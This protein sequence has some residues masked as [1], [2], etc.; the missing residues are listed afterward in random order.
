MNVPRFR[1]CVSLLGGLLPACLSLALIDGAS[2]AE[3]QVFADFEGPTYGAWKATGDAFGAGPATGAL[4]GQMPLSGFIG[5]G[6]VNSFHHGDAGTGTLT[7]PEFTITRGYVAFRIGGGGFEGKTCLNLLVEGKVVRSATGPNTTSGGS[8]ALEPSGWDVRD[9]AG[10]KASL[11]VVDAATGGW[12]HVNLDQVVFTDRKPPGQPRTATREVVLHKHYLQLPVKTGAKQRRL[13]L[14][15]G[16]KVVRECDIELADGEVDWWA[17]M[18]VAPWKGSM[19]TIRVEKLPEGS[20]VLA[21]VEQGDSIRATEPLY[22]ERLRPQFHFS[23]R[24]GWNN[25]PNG[26]VFSQGE[27]HLFYQNNPYGWNWGNMHWAHAVSLDLVH[28]RELPIAIYPREYGDSVFSGSAVVD[29][30][31]TSGWRAGG[32]DELLVAA[33]TST[34]RGECIVYSNDRGR[35][36][37]EYEGNPV[38]RHQGRDPRLFWYEPGKHWVMALYDEAEGKQWITFHT[39]ADLKHWE[40]GSRIEG[41]FECPDMFELAVDGNPAAR[42]WV[43][44]A[45]SSEYRVGTFDGKTFT[46]ETPKLPGHRGEAFYAAQTYSDMPDGRRVQVGWGQMASP[47]MP[48]NQMMCFPCELSLK[49]TPA[50]PRLSWHPASELC[51]LRREA[52]HLS[53]VALSPGGPDPLAHEKAELLELRASIVPGEATTVGFTL[54]GTPVSYDVAR[55]ELTVGKRHAPVPLHEGR[56]ELQILC[57]RTSLE[58]FADQGLVYMPSNVA[59]KGKAARYSTVVTGGTAR[60]ATLDLIPLKSIWGGKPLP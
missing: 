32:K 45:A 36:W 58:V 30:M 21:R 39:S 29:R 15:V 22:R 46:P 7:S 33:F 40:Y 60:L 34:G 50:G 18:D 59:E 23:P 26:L 10:R 56:I 12:G 35:T 31:N 43:L 42:K 9:L 47:G 20:G 27:Y 3:D 52:R 16:G 13:A 19:A 55:Q 2:G 48:F 4:P 54:R 41:F 28:W 1:R 44:T 24:R 49:S 14:V 51:L 57:D 8:E 5:K 11:Q 25:D 6:F 53:K 37:H 38:V 17:P